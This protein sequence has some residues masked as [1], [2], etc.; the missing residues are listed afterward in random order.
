VSVVTK[1]A[2]R[3]WALV[4]AGVAV[5]IC[6]PAA[7]SVASSFFGGLTSDEAPVPAPRAL[8]Q[9]ALASAKVPYSGLAQSTGTLGLPDLP[10]L[11]D[12]AA[13]LGGTTRTRVWWAGEQSWR[14]AVLTSTGE[15]DIYGDQ[16]RTVLWDYEQARLTEVVG[17]SPVRF[18]RADDLLPPQAVRR[19]LGGLGP[20]DR[21]EALP[22]RRSVAGVRAEG[23]RIIPGDARS[24]IGH[25][26]L[27][28]D[29]E[30]GLPIAVDVVDVQGT[31]AVRSQFTDLT[32]TAPAASALRV[33]S[34]PGATHDVTAAA[35]LAGQL[36]RFDG[37]RLPSTLAGVTSSAPI[38]GGTATY[39]SG[40][41]RFVVLPLPGRLAGQVLDA[42]R[43]GGG[44]DLKLP[45]GEALL[46]SSGLVNVVVVR[47]ADQRRAFLV[48][49]LV[50]ADLLSTVTEQLIQFRPQRPSGASG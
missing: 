2:R 27:W 43:T 34:A 46:I 45:G 18:P 19:L 13:E 38:V 29:P 22:G 48:T 32:L 39:G 49:G 14:V 1:Q 7:T 35:D 4:A 41:V 24:T 12:V 36:Q 10:Q 8:I 37:F 3:R 26:D 42:T 5:L 6:L 33:P 17:T 44:T 20:G 23:V 50:S 47:S 30:R 9:R 21:I 25:A 31:T 16:G 11:G 40:L 28:V 15:Q